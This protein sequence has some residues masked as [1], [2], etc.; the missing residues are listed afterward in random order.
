[1]ITMNLQGICA[2][3]CKNNQQSCC[4]LRAAGEHSHTRVTPECAGQEK[5]IQS[6]LRT[7]HYKLIKCL[8]TAAC[9]QD[10]TQGNRAE[11][12]RVT[13]AKT[14]TLHSMCTGERRMGRN[15]EDKGEFVPTHR[16]EAIKRDG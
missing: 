3:G 2:S 9:L 13:A 7:L 16:N 8:I 14:P 4:R 10:A 15:L 12:R 11:T 5:Q 1:M 6:G